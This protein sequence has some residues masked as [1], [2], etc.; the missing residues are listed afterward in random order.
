MKN[1]DLHDELI[2]DYAD[3]QRLRIAFKNVGWSDKDS[4]TI[5]SIISALLHLGNIN[6]VDNIDDNRG[7]K[8]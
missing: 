2:D 7:S 5:F 4:L 6:F 8:F 1:S 3:F